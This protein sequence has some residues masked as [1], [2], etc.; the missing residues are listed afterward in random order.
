MAEAAGAGGLTRDELVHLL[1][2]QPLNVAF[3]LL[4][5]VMCRSA[6]RRVLLARDAL[7][8]QHGRDPLRELLGPVRSQVVEVLRGHVAGRPGLAGAAEVLAA[9]VRDCL[10][11]RG[12]R[13][14]QLRRAVAELR[15][16]GGRVELQ[17]HDP[18]AADPALVPVLQALRATRPATVHLNAR[19][20][21]V[22]VVV[23]PVPGLTLPTGPWRVTHHE[24]ATVVERLG[25]AAGV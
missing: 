11:L 3:V 10:Y 21:A 24:E 14:E 25:E 9:D 19:P 2:V 18:G 13:H 7:D 12:G 17:V 22:S 15:R 6:G 8:A 20:E 23:P 16:A 1:G 5:T 4:I